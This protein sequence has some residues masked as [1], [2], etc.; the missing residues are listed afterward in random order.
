MHVVPPIKR[1]RRPSRSVSASAASTPAT[2]ASPTYSEPINHSGRCGPQ[3]L[4]ALSSPAADDA[5]RASPAGGCGRKAREG[6]P[7]ATLHG[8]KGAEA[9]LV[10]EQRAR[11]RTHSCEL[12]HVPRVVEHLFAVGMCDCLPRRSRVC[13]LLPRVIRARGCVGVWSTVL[14]AVAACAVATPSA[15]ASGRRASQS[16]RAACLAPRCR[17]APLRPAQ[18]SGDSS[19]APLPAATTS[20]VATAVGGPSTARAFAAERVKP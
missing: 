4:P 15:T 18:I 2:L 12:Q 8:Q 1:T 10:V 13:P 20:M 5:S 14:A 9:G 11:Y 17:K 16:S 7:R 3:A 19:S 6:S